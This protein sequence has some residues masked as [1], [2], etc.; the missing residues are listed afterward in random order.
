[1]K[2]LL[3]AAHVVAC[4]TQDGC[5]LEKEEGQNIEANYPVEVS[6][7]HDENGRLTRQFLYKEMSAAA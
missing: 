5:K 6:C 4:K 2:M 1:M 3:R 7:R